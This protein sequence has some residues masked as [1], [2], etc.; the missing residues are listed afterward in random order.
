MSELEHS[1][2]Y[3][4]SD[5]NKPLTLNAA[6]EEESPFFDVCLPETDYCPSERSVTQS[7]TAGKESQIAVNPRIRPKDLYITTRQLATLLHG[8]MPL[9]PALN[10]L[11][12]QLQCPRE[13]L[14][15]TTLAPVIQQIADRVSDGVSLSDAL[16]AYPR[17]FSDLFINMVC[18]G[19]SSG[20]LEEVLTKLADMMEKRNRL[21]GRIKA[22]LAYPALMTI[23]A[24]LVVIFLMAFVVPGISKIFIDMNRQLPWPTTLLIS[25]STFIRTYLAFIAIAVCVFMFA[26]V[27]YLKNETRKMKWDQLKLKLPLIGNLILKIETVRL[28][29]TL[30]IMLSSCIPILDAL[31][32]VKGVIQ[33]SFIADSLDNIKEDIRRGHS[34]A[35]AFKQTALFLPIMYHTI[36]IGEMSGN[37]EEQLINIADTYDNEIDNLTRSLTSL[38]EPVIL[39]LMGLVVGFIVLAMLL[40]IFEIN[41]ML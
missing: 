30:G 10:A 20:T 41:Q 31:D 40:P 6:E 15:S 23:T 28:A 9:V 16:R 22:A 25:I 29:R 37:M 1:H 17:I 12:E 2:T 26:I 13:H 36:A 5:P 19:Q 14:H 8:G 21:A 11:V 34:T 35:Y 7:Q 24:V 18:A 4:H 27:T 38:I 32:I 39:L 33:N 3:C